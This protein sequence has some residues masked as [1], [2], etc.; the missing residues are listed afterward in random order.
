MVSETTKYIP[1]FGW[2]IPVIGFSD[3]RNWWWT[4]L[5]VIQDVLLGFWWAFLFVCYSRHFFC[6]QCSTV[7]PRFPGV[8][9]RLVR[10]GTLSKNLQDTY[11][12]RDEMYA[13]YGQK[14][15]FISVCVMALWLSVWNFSF[16]MVPGGWSYTISPISVWQIYGPPVCPWLSPSPDI[17]WLL[18]NHYFWLPF[19]L[20]ITFAFKPWCVS[21]FDMAKSRAVTVCVSNVEH[22]WAFIMNVR[23]LL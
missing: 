7:P 20:S 13:E 21:Q 22:K 4:S 17:S 5:S 1:E 3:E 14:A 9:Q 12:N 18:L 10:F 6:V 15:P 8:L 16:K 19:C 11:R 23:A 2:R